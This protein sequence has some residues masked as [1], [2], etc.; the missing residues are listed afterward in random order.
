[1]YNVH[2]VLKLVKV[3]KS[4]CGPSVDNSSMTEETA[5]VAFGGGKAF[6]SATWNEVAN[7]LGSS[8]LRQ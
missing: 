7:I 4:L 8:V 2:R 6:D 3:A 5:S 1:M